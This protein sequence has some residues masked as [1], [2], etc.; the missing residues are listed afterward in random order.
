MTFVFENVSK[1][2]SIENYGT[3]FAKL[4]M[5][6]L[7]EITNVQ[8][9]IKT[10][11]VAKNINLY[12]KV[13]FSLKDDSYLTN[14]NYSNTVTNKNLAYVITN[15]N[16]NELDFFIKNEQY[17]YV[18]AN[19]LSKEL[20]SYAQ[21][22]TNYTIEEEND[23][24]F[25]LRKDTLKKSITW[26]EEIV[27]IPY[28]NL[29]SFI[30]KSNKDVFFY[31]KYKKNK[32]KTGFIVDIFIIKK[33]DKTIKKFYQKEISFFSLQ[34]DVQEMAIHV[35]AKLTGKKIYR[36]N[37]YI[38]KPSGALIYLNDKFIGKTPFEKKNEI[39]DKYTLKAIYPGY[40]LAKA[41]ST[42]I[43]EQVEIEKAKFTTNYFLHITNSNQTNL[44]VF[45]KNKNKQKI[46]INVKNKTKV[47]LYLGENLIS[48]NSNFYESNLDAGK[49]F[50]MVENK[51]ME[52]RRKINFDLYKNYDL[53]LNFNIE[54]KKYGV[55]DFIFDHPRN[56][57]LLST[58]GFV[59]AGFGIY[60]M[61]ES[62]KYEDSI[63]GD[64]FN[65]SY[66]FS[67]NYSK[68]LEEGRKT[69]LRNAE[70]LLTTSVLSFFL[71][72]ISYMSHVIDL[73]GDVETIYRHSGDLQFQYKK[74]F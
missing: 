40:L 27:K 10:R 26:Q 31:G 39:G 38:S 65:S 59:S 62:K 18:D 48:I 51:E 3:D 36:K 20:E 5:Q 2:K 57:V 46:S 17:L 73:S 60:A 47:N 52:I 9:P 69:N 6:Y 14:Y 45:N 28:K 68:Y 33:V 22:L 54:K 72:G 55:L 13:T 34:E 66:E 41:D 23:F 30:D 15:F 42:L 74:K 50:L 64:K 11:K 67:D 4:L 32:N 71:T 70:N 56:I 43:E 49:Y 8:Y 16:K 58:L 19:L 25:F 44:F 7:I 35:S 21:K 53:Q 29:E 1:Q 24:K 63:E 12:H 37:K 61:A